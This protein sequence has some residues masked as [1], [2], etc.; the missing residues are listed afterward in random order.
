MNLGLRLLFALL[1]ASI[2]QIGYALAATDRLALVI[3]NSAYDHVSNLPNPVNDAG[4]IAAALER[5]GFDVT[6]GTD[7]DYNRMRLALRD[8][9]ETAQN[10]KVALI[11]FAGHGI[12]IDNTNFLIPVNAQLRSDRDV[13]FETIRLDMAVNSIADV[14][15]LK[16]ILVDACRNNPFLAEMTRTSATRS[17]GRGL[18]RIDPGGVLVGYGARGGTLAQDGDGRNSPYAEALLRHI[19]EPGL[20]LGKMFRKVRDTV[21]DLTDGYQEPF[22]Y[23]SLPGDD[24]FLVP[25]VAVVDPPISVS[26]TQILQDFLSAEIDGTSGAWQSFLN[27]YEGRT[28]NADVVER[29]RVRLALLT[30]PGTNES[31]GLPNSDPLMRACDTFAADPDDPGKPR[32]L[33]GV[34]SHEMDVTAAVSACRLAT[35]GHPES[36]RS[37]YQLF[38]ALSAAGQKENAQSALTR[39]AEL[40][41]SMAVVL[42]AGEMVN[43]RGDASRVARGVDLL[44]KE[45]DL[46][47]AIA[48][49][50]LGQHFASGPNPQPE[51]S[52]QL[53]LLGA[54]RGDMTAKFLIGSRFLA[55]KSSSPE[56]VE[57][58]IGFMTEVADT[59]DTKAMRRLASFLLSQDNSEQ[60]A[61][62]LDYFERAAM[63]ADLN[64]LDQLIQ[65]YSFGRHGLQ[66]DEVKAAE[67]IEFAV[68]KGEAERLVQAGYHREIGYGVA[69]DPAKAA[70]YYFR[71]LREGSAFL[72]SRAGEDWDARTAR[73]LQTLLRSNPDAGYSGAIDGLVGS[74]TL[75]AMRRLCDCR[76]NSVA[77]QFASIF[78]NERTLKLDL[79]ARANVGN[80]RVPNK[81][82]QAF[83][84]RRVFL[85]PGRYSVSP[86]AGAYTAWRFNRTPISCDSNGRNCGDDGWNWSLRIV[87][88][89]NRRMSSSHSG[90]FSTPEAALEAAR[91]VSIYVPWAQFVGFGI[92]DQHDS[93]R[94]NSGGVSISIDPLD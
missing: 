89:D 17:I 25:A 61:L 66:R 12:E 93:G 37:H 50:L 86:T 85:E 72:V 44:E 28:E 52:T 35:A 15:G 76:A 22:T 1:V 67:W 31:T 53:L 51:R 30:A 34:R 65:I 71:A 88:E 73:A 38:R 41:Y 10:A 29:A 3:G 69:A 60:K 47:N 63:S 58:G 40:G 9:S 45:S 43:I 46:G 27:L 75:S 62:G 64:A 87:N 20:E 92:P 26:R 57:T 68:S 81:I 13:E 11:Y 48:A 83:N 78:P 79:N 39:A 2:A 90:P 5:I 82:L 18:G 77:L 6:L 32:A 33:D 70:S 91:P 24:I 4:D 16:I 14:D 49:R 23:G 74:G 59:G 21:Y 36:G 84:Y 7:L 54:N 55:S 80:D 56:D 8:F 19:E 42:A 94:D